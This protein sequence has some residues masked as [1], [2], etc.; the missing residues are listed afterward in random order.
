MHYRSSHGH[1][2]QISLDPAPG[3]SSSHAGG[4]LVAVRSLLLVADGVY[5]LGRPLV[6]HGRWVGCSVLIREFRRCW[7]NWCSSAP[8]VARACRPFG[9]PCM[10]SRY[11]CNCSPTPMDPEGPTEWGRATSRAGP[12]RRR[13]VP[14][15]SGATTARR[16]RKRSARRFRTPRRWGPPGRG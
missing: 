7:M 2:H 1:R 10:R 6:S 3:G 11:P 9:S 5:F 4:R 15:G 8:C 13:A 16:P 12:L 14:P